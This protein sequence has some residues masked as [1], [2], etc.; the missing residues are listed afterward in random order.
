MEDITLKFFEN[1][2]TF[3]SDSFHHGVEQ[4]MRNRPGGVVYD[5][6][7]FVNVVSSSNSRKVEVVEMKNADVLE[8][9]NAE[10][11]GWPLQC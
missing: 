2:H 4:E 10:L 11:E 9:K 5:F 1:G 3:M 6:E 7:D 8:M